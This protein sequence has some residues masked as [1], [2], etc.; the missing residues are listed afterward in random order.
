LVKIKGLDIGPDSSGGRAG[1]S[2]SSFVNELL[3]DVNATAHLKET[4]EEK[5][6]GKDWKGYFNNYLY[7]IDVVLW[8]HE[9]FF[10]PEAETIYSRVLDLQKRASEKSGGSS[11]PSALADVLTLDELLQ[12]C[13]DIQLFEMQM[14][15]IPKREKLNEM[16]GY[17]SSFMD[18]LF[19]LEE[20]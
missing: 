15:I 20:Q 13:D 1:V 7:Y 3:R 12:L 2:S 14:K 10:K 16:I 18:K 4:L 9:Q 19:Q 5:I 6:S 8:Y 17:S 11:N